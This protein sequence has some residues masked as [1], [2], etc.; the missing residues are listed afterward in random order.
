M[1]QKNTA[2]IVKYFPTVSETFIVNQ[3]NALIDQGYHVTLYSYNNGNHAVIHESLLK[4]NLLRNVNYF[5][6]PSDSKLTR[7]IKALKW[8]LKNSRTLNWR[9]LLTSINI[10]KYGKD[11]Y[12]LKLFYELQ[13]F[14]LKND[15]DIIHAHFGMNAKRIAYLK[16]LG[17]IPKKNQVSNHISWLRFIA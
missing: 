13:W 6:K 10:F 1:T 17:F 11:A 14:L 3:I 12:T 8:M 9:L 2:F 7:L 5:V 16:Y 15:F 4:H